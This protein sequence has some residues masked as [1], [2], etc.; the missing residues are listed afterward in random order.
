MDGGR[1]RKEK[2]A[3]SKISGYVWTGP[4]WQGILQL[5]PIFS[6]CALCYYTKAFVRVRRTWSFHVDVLQK[7]AN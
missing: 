5:S 4:K 7:T 2:V 1:I 6:L 3:G